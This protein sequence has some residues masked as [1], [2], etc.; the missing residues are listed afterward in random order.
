MT[1]GY[2]SD[3]RDRDV[4]ERLVVAQPDVEGRPV[5]LHE[6]LLEDERLRLGARHDDLDVVDA[7]G[8][9]AAPTRVSPRWK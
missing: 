8:Q 6:I 1:R 4:R 9:R 2:S 5:A 3:E 7:L